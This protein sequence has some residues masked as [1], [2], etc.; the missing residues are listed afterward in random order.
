MV[1]DID[2][3]FFPW[4]FIPALLFIGLWVFGGG[5]LFWRGLCRNCP[6]LPRRRLKYPGGILAAL[7]TGAC[8]IFVGLLVFYFFH[9]LGKQIET[10]LY[11]AGG[12][13][14]FIAGLV[15]ALTAAY[16]LLGL[17]AKLTLKVAARPFL[18]FICAAGVIAVVVA[19]ISLHQGRAKLAKDDCLRN[20]SE[21][22]YT[23]L[24]SSRS[25]N[26]PKSLQALVD[27]KQVSQSQINCPGAPARTVGYFYIPWNKKNINTENAILLC[28]FA[29]NHAGGRNLLL[30]D[31]K[32]GF[33]SDKEFGELLKLPINQVFAKAL[34]EA[35]KK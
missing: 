2:T 20:L 9:K 12:V 21:I 34:A 35:E 28:D 6:D 8:W 27:Q 17:S 26:A 23:M 18:T 24:A 19:P 14:G 16:G 15:A 32:T 5:W 25:G 7:V 31:W 4:H 3:Y 30:A 1:A 11:L 33:Y 13:A 10:N 22:R 29:E